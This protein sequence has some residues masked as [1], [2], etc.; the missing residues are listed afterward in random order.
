MSS[1][2]H[3]VPV[4]DTA[5]PVVLAS[6]RQPS[7]RRGPAEL[8]LPFRGVISA[9]PAGGMPT[10]QVTRGVAWVTQEGDRR[11]H[12]L[13]AGQQVVLARHGRVVVQAIHRDGVAIRCDDLHAV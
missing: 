2:H 7:P 9:W 6:I 10:V 3:L 5:E 1:P 13:R 8:T 11:D 12:I 4:L